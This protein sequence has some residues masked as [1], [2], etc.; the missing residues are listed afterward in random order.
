MNR[1]DRSA[2][3]SQRH[4]LKATPTRKRD[5]DLSS[6]MTKPGGLPP[7]FWLNELT[8]KGS[9]P[10]FRL[11]L[12]PG[13]RRSCALR[14]VPP[15]GPTGAGR[16]GGASSMHAVTPHAA[17]STHSRFRSIAIQV[18]DIAMHAVVSRPVSVPESA[19]NLVLVHG[20]GLSQRY[21]MPVAC[22][23]ARDCCVYVP[24]QP[25]F[26]GSGHPEQVLDMAGLADGLADW[27]AAAGL[28]RAAF[29]GNSQGCQVI[30]HLAVRHP[31]LVTL[32]VLQGPTTPADERS[33]LW[34]FI[35]WRQN[36]RYNPRSL[37]DVTWS[38]Y[39]KSGYS[40]VLRTFQHS[41]DD[42]I[43]DQAPRVRAP[44]LVVRGEHDPIC[45]AEWARD[46]T[47]LFP[48][49]R[50]VEIPQVA[51][52]LCYTAPV[53]LAQLTR[54]FMREMAEAADEPHQA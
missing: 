20:L 36:D 9:I 43:E 16:V 33:W 11:A 26:G 29:L 37:G 34:Q 8:S 6:T 31:A 17:N 30:A 1:P 10:P 39:K 35:R 15:G 41:L 14:R 23:L 2:R 49:G 42:H 3:I 46:L 19:S 27:M 24:D 45:R 5:Q 38:E 52:T 40:R 4:D 53:A 21:M 44:V 54:A 7:G 51:H 25:G 47:S 13:A 50:F 22:E 32:A 48:K 28:E 12:D 18:G